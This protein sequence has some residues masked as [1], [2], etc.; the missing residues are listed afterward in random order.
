[1]FHHLEDARLSLQLVLVRQVVLDAGNRH[2][3][4]REIKV[5]QEVAADSAVGFWVLCKELNA[6]LLGENLRRRATV[7]HRCCEIKGGWME[8]S[9]SGETVALV[10]QCSSCSFRN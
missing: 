8:G 5:E 3:F 4:Q 10:A 2:A 6:L 9:L 7:G 1:M